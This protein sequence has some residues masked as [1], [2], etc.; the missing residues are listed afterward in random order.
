MLREPSINDEVLRR[1][2]TN[3]L[4]KTTKVRKIACH[5]LLPQLPTRGLISS[6]LLC[7]V[8]RPQ[9]FSFKSSFSNSFHLF[10]GRL[11]FLLSWSTVC[12]TF[13][14]PRILHQFSVHVRSILDLPLVSSIPSLWLLMF[15]SCF[16]L[17]ECYFGWH[18]HPTHHPRLSTS[19]LTT[20][21][22]LRSIVSIAPLS[23]HFYKVYSLSLPVPSFQSTSISLSSSSIQLVSRLSPPPFI[24]HLHRTSI[25][26]GW[27]VK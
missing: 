13:Y 27:F 25:T 15:L 5:L 1:A 20:L 18:T 17:G 19:I 7:F 12:I 24:S 22:F 26:T 6:I 4:I 14:S 2:R 9:S 3:K 8:L 16:R 11:R 23:E 21:V 10:I